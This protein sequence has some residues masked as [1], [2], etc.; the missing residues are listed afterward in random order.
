[1]TM[2]RLGYIVFCFPIHLAFFLRSFDKTTHPTA[3]LTNGTVDKTEARS[4]AGPT[5]SMLSARRSAGPLEIHV[6]IDSATHVDV[7][8]EKK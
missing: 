1:M 4:K 7:E 3:M 6:D 5:M 2:P 8:D